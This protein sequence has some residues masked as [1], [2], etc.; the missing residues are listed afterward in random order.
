MELL[1][2]VFSWITIFLIGSSLETNNELV[3]WNVSILV[4]FFIISIIRNFF[5]RYLVLKKC[6][7][8]WK[9]VA[10]EFFVQVFLFQIFLI[11]VIPSSSF[12]PMKI[13][14]R[15][16]LVNLESAICNTDQ[17]IEKTKSLWG[18]QIDY[19]KVR[20]IYGGLY[21]SL[22]FLEER[23]IISPRGWNMAAMVSGNT[24]Y[25]TDNPNCLPDYL[26]FHEMTHIYQNQTQKINENNFGSRILENLHYYY[27]LITDTQILY[28][29]GGEAGLLSARQNN[30]LFSD[31]SREQQADIVG[32]WYL[33]QIS[34]SKKFTKEYR[35]L[36]KYYVGLMMPS[37]SRNND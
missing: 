37:S 25:L 31:F 33:A 17:Q 21:N 15:M 3:A 35:D 22:W 1:F 36:L 6:I 26:I 10:V 28:D 32:D 14:E 16:N 9:K 34:S 30:K 18:N 11:F 2:F 20:V 13:L 23:E 5:W 8:S 29:Y 24:I 4:G 27:F 19:T 7:Q 12:I